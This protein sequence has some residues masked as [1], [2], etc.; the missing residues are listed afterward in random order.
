M[1][2]EF[3]AFQRNT[4]M[5]GGGP[6]MKNFKSMKPVSQGKLGR[7]LSKAKKRFRSGVEEILLLQRGEA[8]GSPC[9]MIAVK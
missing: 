1:E 9:C 6:G 4:K 2:E 8:K 3:A 5:A 7:T